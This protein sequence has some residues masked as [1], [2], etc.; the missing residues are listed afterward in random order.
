VQRD[1]SGGAFLARQY[2]LHDIQLTNR[3]LPEPDKTRLFSADVCRQMGIRRGDLL[4][5]P[6]LERRVP[7]DVLE[8]LISAEER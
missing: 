7:R 5:M 2:D 8:V 1:L 6:D 3:R 4:R